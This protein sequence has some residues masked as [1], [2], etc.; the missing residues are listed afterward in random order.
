MRTI[1]KKKKDLIFL[2]ILMIAFFALHYFVY[3]DHASGEVPVIQSYTD[4]P[5]DMYELWL[6]AE[7]RPTYLLPWRKVE[8]WY[9]D[10]ITGEVIIEQA[11][12]MFS[13]DMESVQ[14]DSFK[15]YDGFESDGFGRPQVGYSYANILFFILQYLLL[16]GAAYL[17]V[18]SE[19]K[20]S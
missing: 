19:K 18:K 3:L 1:F 16:S 8:F 12:S 9:E 6:S 20:K 14:G 13:S 11:S 17:L 15:Y 10:T 7:K 2:A 5:V 4:A